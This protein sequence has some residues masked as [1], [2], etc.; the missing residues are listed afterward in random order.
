MDP[1]NAPT[2]P[3]PT[4]AKPITPEFRKRLFVNCLP[5]RFAPIS[6]ERAAGND[7]VRE[8]LPVKVKV[9]PASRLFWMKGFGNASVRK[10]P[11]RWITVQEPEGGS[12]SAA[13]KGNPPA[14]TSTNATFA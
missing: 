1:L 4:P 14:A 3:P 8:P 10:S 2:S 11:L 12:E 6:T 7:T 13:L 9:G 5:G